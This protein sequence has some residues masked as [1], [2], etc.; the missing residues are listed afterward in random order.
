MSETRRVGRWDDVNRG[1]TRS[2]GDSTSILAARGAASGAS[3]SPADAVLDVDTL[4][5]VSAR[6]SGCSIPE[7]MAGDPV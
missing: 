6:R 5:I 3:D 2:Q 1:Q 7:E 4:G